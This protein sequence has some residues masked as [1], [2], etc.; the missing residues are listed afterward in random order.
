MVSEHM[1]VEWRFE[2]DGLLDRRRKDTASRGSSQGRGSEA[3]GGL[4][5]SWSCRRPWSCSAFMQAR[6]WRKV[7]KKVNVGQILQDFAFW[8]PWLLSYVNHC[9]ILN[10]V[11]T[12][13]DFYF[14][15][16][17]QFPGID[18]R[19]KK[20][21]EM[22]YDFKFERWSNWTTEFLS[23]KVGWTEWF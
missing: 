20:K 15:R 10:R 17:I 3:E 13:S 19:S 23:N 18:I 5:H 14:Q 2:G 6:M 7:N 9:Q 12:L 4:V 22:K 1:R 8:G 16:I 11:L 21:W